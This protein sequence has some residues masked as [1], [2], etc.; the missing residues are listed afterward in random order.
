MTHE[1]S[2]SPFTNCILSYDLSPLT[3]GFFITFENMEYK[4]VSFKDKLMLNYI[5]KIPNHPA[6]IRLVN[7]LND[8]WLGGGLNLI[9]PNG[10]KYNFSTKEFI[11]HEII[12][13]G[14][15]EP[16]TLKLCEEIL[17]EGG[18]FVDIGANVGLFSIHLSVN[19]NVSTYAVEPSFENFQRLI[20]NINRNQLS[21]VTPANIGLSCEDSFG[22]LVNHS[23]E[24]SGTFK[25]VESHNDLN[26]YLIRLTTLSELLRYLKIKEIDLIKIDIEGYEMNVFKGLFTDNNVRPKNIVMEFSGLMERTGYTMDDCYNY[27]IALGYRA[28][29]VLGGEY[30]LGDSVPE[31]NI[32][33]KYN[34]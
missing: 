32:W 10:S 27:F 34:N 15:Y 7:W 33:W 14:S 13:S 4:G 11:G 3:E 1:R 5:R 17:Q 18:V 28:Y 23:V 8:I 26:S 16:L 24:N 29:D 9:S 12:Y 2:S 31:C 21:N 6:K 20:N 30:K 22:Y 25:V 19:K